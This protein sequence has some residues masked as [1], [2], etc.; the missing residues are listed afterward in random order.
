MSGCGQPWAVSS[1]AQAAGVAALNEH[2][3]SL[4]LRQLVQKERP[5]LAEELKRLGCQVCPG[6]ANY[7]LFR[8]PVRHLGASMRA[9][10]ILIRDCGNFPG[11]GP[12]WY[13]VAV[14]TEREN[15]ALLKA[16]GEV[17]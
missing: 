2:E 17:L 7:L 9:K 10:G 11:L 3:Y 12:G 1:V 14:R 4:E 5:R 8:S 6:E 16:M 15:A 13:R